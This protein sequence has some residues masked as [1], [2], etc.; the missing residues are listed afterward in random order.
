MSR[1]LKGD[2]ERQIDNELDHPDT[3]LI[4][5]GSIEKCS[6][7]QVYKVPSGKFYAVIIET[8]NGWRVCIEEITESEINDYVE[9][10]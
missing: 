3:I 5:E 7:Y 10:I 9:R 2:E 6:Q 8:I 1:I 4:G